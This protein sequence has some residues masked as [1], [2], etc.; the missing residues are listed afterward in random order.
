[1]RRVAVV[2]VRSMSAVSVKAAQ[3]STRAIGPVLVRSLFVLFVLYGCAGEA[4]SGEAAASGLGLARTVGAGDARGGASAAGGVAGTRAQAVAETAQAKAL[5]AQ[6]ASAGGRGPTWLAWEVPARSSDRR[7]CCFDDDF[8]PGTCMLEGRNRGWGSSDDGPPGSGRL[9]VLA[10]WEDGAVE[11]VFAVDAECPVD[12]GRVPIE[13]LAGVSVE[14]SV[15]WL[16][17]LAV[18]AETG[19]AVASEMDDAGE[20]LSALSQHGGSHA[21]RALEALASEPQPL[22]LRE[23]ALFWIGQSRG[24][25]GARFLAGVVRGDPDGDVREKAIFSLSQNDSEVSEQVLKEAAGATRTTTCAGKLSSGWRRRSP[26]RRRCYSRLS[27]KIRPT[28]CASRRS[29]P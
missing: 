19:R 23:K 7:L 9:Q 1:V 12:S 20:P 10:R 15:D 24:E 22:D 25:E 3:M 4:A 2:R 21:T 26:V 13:R 5:A 18:A 6:I 8:N 17:A 14:A 11:R 28:T 27:T 16:A 29:S